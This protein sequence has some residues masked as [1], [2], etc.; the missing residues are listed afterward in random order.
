M[1]QLP[2]DVQSSARKSVRSNMALVVGLLALFGLPR[3]GWALDHGVLFVG[4]SYTSANQLDAVYANLVAEGKPGWTDVTI[5]R[6]T[7]GGYKLSQHAVDASNGS[8]LDQWLHGSDPKHAWT[9]VVLQDQSQVPSFPMSNQEFQLSRA[10]AVTLAKEI[11]K[12]GAATQLFMTWGRRNGDARNPQINPDFLSMQSNLAAGYAS[13]NQAI[14]AAGE[15]AKTIPVGLAF[16]R[17]YDAI[18]KQGKDPTAGDTLFMRLYSGDGSHPSAHGTYLAACTMYSA[19]LAVTPEGLQS[20][21][22]GVSVADRAAL[23]THAWQTVLAE[24]NPGGSGGGSAAATSGSGGSS[25][26]ASGSA[27][28]GSAASGSAASGSGGMTGAGGATV[29]GA[30]SSTGQGGAGAGN[31]AIAT[32]GSGASGGGTTTLAATDA[33]GCTVVRAPTG[34]P[35]RGS[36]GRLLAWLLVVIGLV[37]RDLKAVPT[38]R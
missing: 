2:K 28:S 16:K 12:K 37:A 22:N 15:S 23:Q 6:Y 26:A 4:N 8:Q 35:L 18:T 34:A 9:A 11:A 1:I 38:R 14:V 20:A 5:V 24:Q 33:Q 7:K 21:P 36:E 13:Y 30:S 29:D 17:V 3:A 19:L 31:A 27:A 25:I 32:A 10:G